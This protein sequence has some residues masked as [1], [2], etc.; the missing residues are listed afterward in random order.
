MPV[1][2]ELLELESHCEIQIEIVYAPGTPTS[3]SSSSWHSWVSAEVRVSKGH[4]LAGPPAPRGPNFGAP[5]DYLVLEHATFRRLR[6]EA[7][8]EWHGAEEDALRNGTAAEALKVLR[9]LDGRVNATRAN[10]EKTL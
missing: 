5:G 1:I 4:R 2:P 9:E 7:R 8:E 6:G 3:A 10:L